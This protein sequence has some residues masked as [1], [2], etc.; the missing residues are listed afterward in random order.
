MTVRQLL[1]IASLT[2]VYGAGCAS[3]RG[4]T[5][6]NPKRLAPAKDA[7]IERFVQSWNANAN[8]VDSILVNNVDISGKAEGKPIPL[9]A[10]LGFKQ[11]NN[12][13]MTGESLGGKSEVDLGSN[14][15][16]IWFWIARSTP[17]AVYFCK[18]ED[19]GN[20]NIA[21]PFHPDWIM[22]LLGVS[23]IDA[24]KYQP[25]QTTPDFFTLVANE[26]TPTGHAVIKRLII[27]RETGRLS[28]I[29]LF[30]PQNKDRPLMMATIREYYDDTASGL[31]VPSKI[32]MEW[33]DSNTKVT[34]TLPHKEI[35]LNGI[36]PEMASSIFQ[37]HDGD[38]IGGVEMVDI[39]RA[40][41]TVPV[42]AQRPTGTASGY[43]PR[44]QPASGTR[45]KG[46]IQTQ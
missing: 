43:D 30:N 34:I 16:E 44:L 15:E 24:A 46:V 33:P 13:R 22:D 5:A 41:R 32:R 8:R 14:P 37:R 7:E 10:K 2:A 42:S 35:R 17:P 12:F 3:I 26:T 25:G 9:T 4:F 6:S 40:G 21:M 18:R 39:G 38:Y 36:S 1:V 20:V 45:L 29:E 11:P 27:D 28:G 31:F 19:F 23:A